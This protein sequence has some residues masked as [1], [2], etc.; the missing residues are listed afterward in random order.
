LELLVQDYEMMDGTKF[1]WNNP[2]LAAHPYTNRDPRFY[3][4][5]LYDG[6]GWKIRTNIGVTQDPLNQLQ[7]GYYDTAVGKQVG[8]LDTRQS[9]IENWNASW[10]GYNMRK[11]IDPDEKVVD[12]NTRQF[13]PYPFIRYTELVFNY[14]EACIAL[15]DDADALTWLNKI[16]YRAGMPKLTVTGTALRDEYRNERRIEMAYEEQRYHDARRWMIA[17]ATLGRKVLFINV[18]GTLKS[19]AKAPSP[20]HHDETIFNYSYQPIQDAN[21]EVRTWLDKM[22]FRPITLDEMNKNSKLVQNPGY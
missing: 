4:D 19:G 20:Y 12:N 2:V 22:Y 3:A 14:A 6:A 10:S 8:G 16:R 17:P 5:I 18:T 15:G 1:D 11:F 7:L 21:F 9:P 13:I